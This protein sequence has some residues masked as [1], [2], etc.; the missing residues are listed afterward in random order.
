MCVYGGGGGGG[1]SINAV[2]LNSKLFD[3]LYVYFAHDCN[4]NFLRMN[5][6]S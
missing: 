6:Y 1:D 3:Y 4:S 5:K 2:G